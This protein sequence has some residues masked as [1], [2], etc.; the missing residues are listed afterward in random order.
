MKRIFFYSFFILLAVS[1]AIDLYF[2]PYR[3]LAEESWF[4]KLAAIANIEIQAVKRWQERGGILHTLKQGDSGAEVLLLQKALAADPDLFQVSD[5]SGY[6]GDKTRAAILNFQKQSGFQPTG[7][8]DAPTLKKINEIYFS[9]LCPPSSAA[10]PDFTFYRVDKKNG[11][12]EAF[13]PPSLID[14]SSAVKTAG[15]ICL[16]ADVAPYLTA[17]VRAA[18]DS[19]IY[20]SVTSG[21]RRKEIQ[22]LLYDFWR[23]VQGNAALDE[24]APPGHSEHQLGTAI[25]LSGASIGYN[26]VDPSFGTA[27][28]GRWLEENAARWGFIMSYPKGK[29]RITGY[30]YE[31]WHYRF[32]GRELAQSLKKNQLAYA[33]YARETNIPAIKPGASTPFLSA[34]SFI[35]VW[36]NESGGQFSLINRQSEMELPIASL[37]K[38][39]TAMTASDSYPAESS[40]VIKKEALGGKGSLHH[41]RAG[42]EFAAAELAAAMLVESDNEAAAALAQG[43]PGGEKEFI[44]KMQ[45]KAAALGLAHTNF[46][47]PSGLDPAEPAARGNYSSAREVAHMIVEVKTKYP[48][49]FQT[50]GKD[51][52]ELRT[53]DGALHHT[54]TSTDE[55]LWDKSFPLAILGGKTGETPRAKKNLALA[56]A[57]PGGRGYI[58]NVVLASDDHF[59]DMRKLAAWVA[60]SF[61]W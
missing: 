5:V 35:S 57:S 16:R 7:A 30:I 21:F 27:K 56:T 26:A 49:L 31:P 50:L 3:R 11:L 1:G 29:E 40:V 28:E 13:V 10:F 20:L 54:A 42:E 41:F 15:T 9:E 44:A 48:R 46:T 4:A 36:V 33:E 38:L 32:V 45:T 39:M 61:D 25:D 52:Y 59:A 60:A 58:I 23:S 43:M 22:E 2:I 47:S 14:I 24:I 51:K 34:K 8:V 12:P 37:T 19:G 6:F 17:M 18:K 53:L 55:L